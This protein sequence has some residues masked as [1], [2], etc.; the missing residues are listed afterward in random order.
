MSD[1]AKFVSTGADGKE[2]ELHIFKYILAVMI[3]KGK[4]FDT[5][6]LELVRVLLQDMELFAD[7]VV[8]AHADE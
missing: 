3:L 1:S 4:E 2:V 7:L 8:S 5:K 6:S